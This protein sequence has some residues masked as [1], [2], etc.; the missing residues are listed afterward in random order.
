MPVNP[1]ELLGPTVAA[2][3]LAARL[4]YSRSRAVRVF[5]ASAGAVAANVPVGSVSFTSFFLGIVGPVSAATL[6]LMAGYLYAAFAKPDYTP[7]RSFLACLVIIGAIFYPLTFG[8]SS[9]DP[10]ELG[11]R[12][13]AVPLLMLVVAVMGWAAHAIDVLCWIALTALLYVIGAYDSTNLWDYLIF[14][15]D[16]IL[17]LAW[18][19]L[20]LRRRG[21]KGNPGT[22]SVSGA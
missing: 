19:A 20:E 5:A 9:F 7:S 12:G 10:Y 18:L 17:A 14:P 6:V 22:K 21:D 1:F 16:P 2:A 8:L 4:T 13:L 11:Y 3:A 15:V